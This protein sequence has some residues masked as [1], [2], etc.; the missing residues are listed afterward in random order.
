[1]ECPSGWT[2]HKDQLASLIPAVAAA[3]A[4]LFKLGP[5][6]QYCSLLPL[7]MT[8]MLHLPLRQA[9]AGGVT[10]VVAPNCDLSQPSGLPFP[11]NALRSGDL[12]KQAEG[13]KRSLPK[14]CCRCFCC[15]ASAAASPLLPPSPLAFWRCCTMHMYAFRCTLN[16]PTQFRLEQGRGWGK[17]IRIRMHSSLGQSS[18]SPVVSAGSSSSSSGSGQAG[19]WCLFWAAGAGPGPGPGP[20]QAVLPTNHGAGLRACGAR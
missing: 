11:L 20:T 17:S 15:A 14:W 13:A 2:T 6:A 19:C 12:Q 18:G 5:L 3:A 9:E 7:G 10:A 8:E 4:S 1:M 16:C